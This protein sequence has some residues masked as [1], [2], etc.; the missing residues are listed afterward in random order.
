MPKATDDVSMT[1]VL[2]YFELMLQFNSKLLVVSFAIIEPGL[3]N[4]KDV[5][6]RF[7]LRREDGPICA[8]ANLLSSPP[9]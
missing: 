2:A 4:S 8:N 9:P 3:F 6:I 7:V 5:A 1:Q